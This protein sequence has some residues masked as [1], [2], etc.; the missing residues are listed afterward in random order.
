MPP[1]KNVFKILI[2]KKEEVLFLR[3]YKERGGKRKEKPSCGKNP[4]LSSFL[5]EMAGC[6]YVI[7][8]E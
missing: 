8:N 4:R 6:D 3:K 1:S 7:Y 2:K 5:S